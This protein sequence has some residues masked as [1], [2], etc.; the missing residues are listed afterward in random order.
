[1][2]RFVLSYLKHMMAFGME[3]QPFLEYSRAAVQVH[4]RAVK[5][6][7]SQPTDKPL[8]IVQLRPGIPAARSQNSTDGWIQPEVSLI[9]SVSN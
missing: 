9:Q 6:V 3:D 4:V 1:M 2:R 8:R 5:D 7:Q